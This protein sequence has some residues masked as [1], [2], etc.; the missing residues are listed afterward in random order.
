MRARERQRGWPV[1][2]THRGWC[3]LGVRGRSS[4]MPGMHTRTARATPGPALH[5]KVLAL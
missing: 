2:D 4:E 1:A 5:Q 3:I